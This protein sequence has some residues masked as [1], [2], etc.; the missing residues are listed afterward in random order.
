MRGTRARVTLEH[1]W[2][3]ETCPVC[4]RK[5]TRYCRRDEWGYWYNNSI[6]QIESKLT[7]LCSGECARKF[8]DEKLRKTAL[9][10]AGTK[11]FRARQMY[12]GGMSV[13]DIGRAIG[14]AASTVSALI[15]NLENMHYQECKWLDRHPEEVSA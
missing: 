4:G 14:V 6:M 1:M 8:A 7:L 13:S 10:L 12:R 2:P 5:W 11:A 15:S 9:R 3:V